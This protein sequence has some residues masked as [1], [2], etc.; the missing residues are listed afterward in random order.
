MAGMSDFLEDA[1]LNQLFRTSP[2]VPP[3]TL[4]IGLSTTNP[5]DDGTNF[6]EPSGNAYA[7]K[8]VTREDAQFTA[9]GG[10][11]ETKNVNDVIFA[12]ASGGAWGIVTHFGVFDL[13]A[14]GNMLWSGTLLASKVINDGDQFKFPADQLIAT[15]D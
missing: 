8:D 3:A 7:R 4:Y 12:Q 10:T 6:T 14:G 1:I 15:L 5:A 13:L 9:P 2:Y 11:G